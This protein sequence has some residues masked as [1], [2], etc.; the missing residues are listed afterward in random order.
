CGGVARVL[1]IEGAADIGDDHGNDLL[2]A[3]GW[4]GCWL[5]R[6]RRGWG[7]RSWRRGARL[8]WRRGPGCN[9]RCCRQRLALRCLP[10]FD[11]QCPLKI[12]LL[13]QS[14]FVN[15][16]GNP[17]DETTDRWHKR[18]KPVIGS[19]TTAAIEQV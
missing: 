9:R 4:L 12:F 2:V 18:S 6:R 11:G 19:T 15:H 1:E 10:L 7:R 5:T 13:H 8:G 14:P 3:T 16:P 17:L